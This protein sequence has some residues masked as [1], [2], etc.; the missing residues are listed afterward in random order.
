MLI[1][2]NR[3]QPSSTKSAAALLA[4]FGEPVENRRHG[5]NSSGRTSS[6]AGS[7]RSG[8]GAPS[9]NGRSA[10]A[11]AAAAPHRPA[12]VAEYTTAM[13]VGSRR[14]KPVT[15]QNGVRDAADQRGTGMPTHVP[16]AELKLPEFLRPGGAQERPQAG[17]VP[18]NRRCGVPNGRTAAQ[19]WARQPLASAT[20]NRLERLVHGPSSKFRDRQQENGKAFDK[21]ASEHGQ[22]EAQREHVDAVRTGGLEARFWAAAFLSMGV[23]EPVSAAKNSGFE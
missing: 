22:R 15:E 5:N 8:K 9:R 14:P 18:P 16:E 21:T 17:A 12:P 19:P 2:L 23:M 20:T 7:R 6:N 10:P 3:V 1:A 4:R 13:A 11:T